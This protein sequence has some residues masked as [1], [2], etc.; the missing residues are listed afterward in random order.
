MNELGNEMNCN[1]ARDEKF[2]H[3]MGIQ[4]NMRCNINGN[5]ERIQDQNGYIYCVD[6]YGFAVTPLFEPEGNNVDCDQFIY[7]AEED[8]FDEEIEYED[9]YDEGTWGWSREST[10]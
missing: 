1:C 3:D 8:I 10:T 4:F 2:F 5:Y 6:V 9:E 7:T